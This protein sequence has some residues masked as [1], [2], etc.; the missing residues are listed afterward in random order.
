MATWALKNLDSTDPATVVNNIDTRDE[1]LE[2]LGFRSDH[3]NS[4]YWTIEKM[5]GRNAERWLVVRLTDNSEYA[6]TRVP[7]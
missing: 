4:A 1:A 2:V 3:A 7:E 5:P 6:L